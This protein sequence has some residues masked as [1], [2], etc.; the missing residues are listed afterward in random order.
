MKEGEGKDENLTRAFLIDS[1]FDIHYSRESVCYNMVNLRCFLDRFGAWER[2]SAARRECEVGYH[3]NPQSPR[4]DRRKWLAVQWIIN[5]LR[6]AGARRRRLETESAFA[7]VGRTCSSSMGKQTVLRTPADSQDSCTVRW[8]WQDWETR[9]NFEFGMFS[10]MISVEYNTSLSRIISRL[11]L[12]K[13]EINVMKSA[14]I[15]QSYLCPGDSHTGIPSARFGAANS[16]NRVEWWYWVTDGCRAR[17]GRRKQLLH[18]SPSGEICRPARWCRKT[19]T[20][21]FLFKARHVWKP[22]AVRI[23]RVFIYPPRIPPPP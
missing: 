7:S 19:Q 5:S 23:G 16:K 11:H 13:Y 6:D 17:L 8:I 9:L 22:L 20:K 2:K 10:L 15:K 21:P 18:F 14:P 3:Q 12:W 4:S 1:R